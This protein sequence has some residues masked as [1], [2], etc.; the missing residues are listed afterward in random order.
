MMNKSKRDTEMFHSN[1]KT[2]LNVYTH[3]NDKQREQI[4]DKLMEFMSLN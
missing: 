3:L 4:V 2:I 1:V